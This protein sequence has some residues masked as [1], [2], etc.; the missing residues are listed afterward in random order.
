MTSGM[1]SVRTSPIR[2]ASSANRWRTLSRHIHGVVVQGVSEKLDGPP[3]IEG[4]SDRM[5]SSGV[6]GI[7]RVVGFIQMN[8][9]TKSIPTRQAPN[10]NDYP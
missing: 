10:N 1:L 6:A 2:W 8:P 3:V 5:G 4:I 9:T 7:R